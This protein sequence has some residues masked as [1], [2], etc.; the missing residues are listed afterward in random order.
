LEKYI[1][2]L[3]KRLQGVEGKITNLK[4]K[5]CRQMEAADKWRQKHGL[6][7]SWP[8]RA[9][10][11]AGKFRVLNIT[12]ISHIRPYSAFFFFF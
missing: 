12:G 4:Q 3:L 2:N 5:H 10:H 6:G 9:Q 11:S 7:T 1:R 8:N